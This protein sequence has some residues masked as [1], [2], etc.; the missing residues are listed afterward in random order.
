MALPPAVS[1]Q[2]WLVARKELL[3]RRKRSP[4]RATG[5]TPSAADYPWSG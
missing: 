5:S 1:R 2:E 3:A 4:G